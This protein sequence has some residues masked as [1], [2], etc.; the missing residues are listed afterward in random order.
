MQTVNEPSEKP[1]PEQLR[2]LRR[3]ANARGETFA[4]PQS[5]AEAEG[6]LE[7]LRSRAKSSFAEQA[8][9]RR[10]VSQDMASRGG[11]AAVQDSEVVGYGASARWAVRGQ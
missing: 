8:V 2:E 6:E 1:H 10:Q 9:E 4:W 5:S 7:R 3:A 11:A